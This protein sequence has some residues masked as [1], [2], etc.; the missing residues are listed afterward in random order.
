MDQNLSETGRR[1]TRGAIGIFL[2]DALILPTGFVTAVFL[3]RYLGPSAYGLFALVSRLILWIEWGSIAG[4]SDT[5]LKFIGEAQN[6][7]P[8]AAAIVRLH[9]YV[10]VV[11]GVLIWLLAPL[12]AGVFHEP[13]MAGLI[14]IFAM[15]IPIHSLM[16][17]H[18][19]IMIGR[20]HYRARAR[21][22][23]IR[24]IS[25][26]ILIVVFVSMGL[27]VKGAV[28]GSV[29]AS[30]IGLLMS[31]YYAGL[32]LLPRTTFPIRS[33]LNFS[34]P[35]YLSDLSMR[36]F[37][38]DLFLL[39]ILGSTASQAGFYG[40]ALNLSLPPAIFS[41]SLASPLLST[42]SRTFRR[43]DAQKS[44]ELGI[45]ALRSTFWLAPF[46]AIVAGTAREIVIF[47]FGHEYLPAS[48]PL[49]YLIFAAVGLHALHISRS[50]I[51]AM[52]KP[53]L[54]FVLA[55][56]MVP[57][58]LA[59]HLICIPFLGGEGAAM[60]TMITALL[61]SLASLVVVQRTWSLRP[62]LKTII[63][64]TACSILGFY[65]GVLWPV[66][67]WLLIV[68]LLSLT[69]IIL[70]CFLLMREFSA[71]ELDFIRSLFSPKFESKENDHCAAK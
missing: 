27:S 55:G 39:K 51:I 24:W 26:L 23:A 49:K 44:K 59:G 40:A 54:T 50:I 30:L 47:I 62:P 22:S 21:V 1:M 31:L 2:A 46:A 43:G 69:L 5:A 4:F 52:D 3:S 16:R 19:S 7:R 68:K 17:A 29:A 18:L 41:K 13:A 42:L 36:F 34:K 61:G 56:P 15:E 53:G 38:L 8:V 11:F 48:D 20:E 32:P 37:R 25:R 10:G 33:L 28:M 70:M 64:G 45:A 67:G 14:R 6:W 60:V 57:F 71:A 65:L 63:N 9:F 66:S 12:L 58:A 35:L